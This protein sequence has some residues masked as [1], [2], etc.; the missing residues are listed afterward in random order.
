MPEYSRLPTLMAIGQA[1]LTHL[2]LVY[3]TEYKTI[4]V[5]NMHNFTHL[6]GSHLLRGWV[7]KEKE[8]TPHTHITL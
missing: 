2:I 6:Q 4:S 5:N 3:F 1:L 7:E 8:K